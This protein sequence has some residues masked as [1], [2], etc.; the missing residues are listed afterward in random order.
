MCCTYFFSKMPLFLFGTFC[1]R[2]IFN[3]S[4][5]NSTAIL[6]VQTSDAF[7]MLR[8]ICCC[9]RTRKVSGVLRPL[10]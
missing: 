4:T 9:A 2:V 1:L 8:I 10:A 3:A 5:K 6:V 7:G